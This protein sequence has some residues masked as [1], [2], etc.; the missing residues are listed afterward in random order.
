MVSKREID[1]YSFSELDKDVQEK[2]IERLQG[3]ENE[4]MDM[5][6]FSEYAK[7]YIEEKGFEDVEIAYSLGYSQGD[8]F[9][10]TGQVE[11][12]DKFIREWAKKYQPLTES[13]FVEYI[14]IKVVRGN[15][16]YSHENTVGFEIELEFDGDEIEQSGKDY[17]EVE[18]EFENLAREFES[19]LDEYKDDICKQ[20]E[21]DGY[22]EIEAA[23]SEEAIKEMIDDNNYDFDEEG[24]II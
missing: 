9:S 5:D 7:N 11:Y 19:T 17:D 13:T 16:H 8:G 10:F 2:V 12:P 1:V 18:K 20:L 23:T 24:N 14:T 22:S 4:Y 15:S 3:Q 6:F 21:K